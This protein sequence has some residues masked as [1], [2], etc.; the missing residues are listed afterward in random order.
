M[1]AG[2]TLTYQTRIKRCGLNTSR[3]LAFSARPP[4]PPNPQPIKRDMEKT[5]HL[6]LKKQPF[7][8]MVTGEKTNEYREPKQWIL[9]R[10]LNKYGMPKDYDFVRLVNGYGADKPYFIAEYKGWE[11]SKNNDLI[12][13]SNGLQVDIAPWTIVIHLGKIIEI[14]NLAALNKAS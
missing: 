2:I 1:L 8:V 5:L 7:E 10:L 14:G 9:S 13:Y 12:T 6:S 11:R 4:A 3:L